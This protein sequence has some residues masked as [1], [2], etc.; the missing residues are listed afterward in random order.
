MNVKDM[1]ATTIAAI[2]MQNDLARMDTI[3][4]NLANVLTPGYK[5]QIS[6]SRAFSAQMDEGLAGANPSSAKPAT[7]APTIA[8]DASAGTLRYTNNPH[9]VAIDGEG[10]F[11]I[12]GPDG[13]AYTRQGNLRA[14]AQGRLVG[15]QGLPVMG[16]GGEIMVTNAPITVD[17]N[18][19]VRQGDRL[20]GRLKVVR[21][22]N[23]G[24][25]TPAGGGM[26]TSANARL[27]EAG[28]DGTVKAGYLENSNVNSPQ[29]M[30]RMTETVRHFEALQ[31]IM[32]GYDEA[33]DKTFRKLGEF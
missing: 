25:L 17:A 13:L 23:P 9:D 15:A 5:K 26:Y 29:E 10:F 12:A 20:A 30:V 6:V 27:A 1:S 3:S 16:M 32:Q 19:D 33:L 14:D 22:A 11:E 7:S 28:K 4:H 31:K 18:G 21:F 2:G 8:L 24:A